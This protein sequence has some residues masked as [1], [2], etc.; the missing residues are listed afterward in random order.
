MKSLPHVRSGL[1]RHHLDAEVLI[2]DSRG[3]K[4]HLLDPTTACVMELLE[5]GGWTAEGIRSEIPTR[6]GFAPIEGFLELAAEELRAAGLLVG[7]AARPAASID[8]VRREVI[9]KAAIAGAAAL[10]VPAITTLTATRGY[11]QA[12]TKRADCAPCT[13]GSQCSSGNCDSGV[14]GG[15]KLANGAS[16]NANAE[17]CSGTCSSLDGIC[18]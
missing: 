1:L 17:C 9:R 10:L 15:D 12:T 7:S 14:C 11:A 13:K 8:I 4:V 16:C 2:Y 3:D 18:V 5:E 6:L